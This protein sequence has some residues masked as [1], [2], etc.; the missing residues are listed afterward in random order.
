MFLDLTALALA[1]VVVLAPTFVAPLVAV[2]AYQKL[3]S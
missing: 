2:L 1:V 3:S